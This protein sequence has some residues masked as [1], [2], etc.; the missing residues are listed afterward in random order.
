MIGWA[1]V[2]G[3]VR[4]LYAAPC[5]FLS[6]SGVDFGFQLEALPCSWLRIAHPSNH[7]LRGPSSEVLRLAYH[8]MDLLC[9]HIP[10]PYG[11]G[12]AFC[13]GFSKRPHRS[14]VRSS[15][16]QACLLVLD[17]RARGN[18]LCILGVGADCR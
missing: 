10:H 14:F 4:I 15:R 13:A 16:Q 1:A 5:A 17:S 18:I 7:H 6:F 9:W 11:S 12:C 2:F 8:T 3:L